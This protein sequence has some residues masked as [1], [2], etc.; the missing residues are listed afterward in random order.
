MAGRMRVS[1]FLASMFGSGF[2]PFASG[3][4]TTLVIGVPLCLVGLLWT[5]W[6]PL[7]ALL[8]CCAGVPLAARAE[9]ILGRKDSGIITIDEA[10]GF[11]VTMVAVPLTPL[12]LGVGFVLFRFFDIFKPPPI[13]MLQNLP[14]GWGVMMD[15]V[16]AGI[17]ANLILQILRYVLTMGG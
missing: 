12:Y 3:T 14:R 6:V 13:N 10:A 8:L 17:Y 4:F 15:D 11:L 16:V 1:V 9:R 7:L 5:P 2:F